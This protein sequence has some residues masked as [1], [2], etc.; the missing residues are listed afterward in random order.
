MEQFVNSPN[1]TTRRS[2]LRTCTLSKMLSAFTINASLQPAGQ[3]R[4][5]VTRSS[6][7]PSQEAQTSRSP[8]LGSDDAPKE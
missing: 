8:P 2:D 6:E 5:W 4:T 3:A 1:F 7:S